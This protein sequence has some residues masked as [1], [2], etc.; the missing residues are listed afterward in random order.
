MRTHVGTP[1]GAE[2]HLLGEGP[3]WDAAADRLL[4]VDI[5]AG[6]VL[7]GTLDGPTIRIAAR[8][9]VD[10]TVGAVAPAA[11]GGVVV[12]AR[13]D[14]LWLPDG[15]DGTAEPVRL[16]RVLDP[17]AGHR[18]N[19]GEC[20]PAGRFLVGSLTVG[21]VAAARGDDVL[22]R[23]EDDGTL[24][25][26]DADLALSNGLAWTADGGTLFSVDTGPRVVWARDYDPDGTALGHRREH[27]RVEGGRPDGI[28]MDVDGGLWVAV[29]GAG[30]ARRYD[31]SGQVTDVVT[32]PAP[33]I[34]SVGFAG[35][36]LGTLVITTLRSELSPDQAAAYPESGRLFTV[37]PG[38]VGLPRPPWNGRAARATR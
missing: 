6:E 32:V 29:Y 11:G 38:F 1:A 9:T 30:E 25:T 2:L 7:A 10:R 24:T 17:D 28:C 5:D 36:D 16:A 3:V 33:G 35:P 12:G 27:L 20:D 4:W 14:I 37:R 21:G 34:T 19:D 13:T 8:R 18:L 26:L 31:R 22:V 23:L 15:V